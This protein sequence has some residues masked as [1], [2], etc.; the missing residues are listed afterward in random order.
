MPIRLTRE[1]FWSS[2]VGCQAI[3][4]QVVEVFAASSLDEIAREWC[5]DTHE[6]A[7]AYL[8]GPLLHRVAGFAGEGARLF[9]LQEYGRK[10]I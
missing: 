7:R 5:F 9:L 4:H 10:A 2:L 6:G 1:E 3:R 8:R